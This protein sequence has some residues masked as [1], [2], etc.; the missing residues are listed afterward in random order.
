[1]LKTTR[2][3]S[4]NYYFKLCALLVSLLFWRCPCNVHL[5]RVLLAVY[6]YSR[7]IH[8]DAEAR[9]TLA[10][11]V[12]KRSLLSFRNYPCQPTQNDPNQILD[13]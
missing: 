9:I 4:K 1:M 8:G 6:E 10:D 11:H 5:G 2:V 7:I 12:F 3:I 13:F